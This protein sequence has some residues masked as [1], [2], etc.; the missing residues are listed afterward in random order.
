MCVACLS[1]GLS[2]GLSQRCQLDAT[3]LVG[4]LVEQMRVE[5]ARSKTAPARVC[6]NVRACVR[7][8][9]CVVCCVRVRVRLVGRW[10]I[11]A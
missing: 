6:T 2:D 3:L 9:V 7:A 5:G 11:W 1:S 10:Q 8:C 4:Q